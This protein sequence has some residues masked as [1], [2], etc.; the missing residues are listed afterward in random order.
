MP[1]NNSDQNQ[2]NRNSFT[3]NPN[4]SDKH[5]GYVSL[6]PQKDLH[7]N[8]NELQNTYALHPIRPEST[9][10]RAPHTRQHDQSNIQH[11]LQNPVQ[12]PTNPAQT[13]A[14]NYGTLHPQQSLS[15]QHTSINAPVNP[16]SNTLNSSSEKLINP[17]NFEKVLGQENVVRPV[18]Q[19]L[20]PEERRMQSL[21]ISQNLKGALPPVEIG[22]EYKRNIPVNTQIVLNRNEV[23]KLIIYVIPFIAILFQ[24]VKPIDDKDFKWHIKQSL[25]AQ[26]VWFFVM[27]VLNLL[28]IYILSTV[29]LT[30]WKLLGYITILITGALAYNGQRMHIPIAYDLGKNFIEEK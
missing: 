29:G 30:L 15:H 14:Q 27:I 16:A 7:L 5:I 24:L 10:Q 1:G 9:N 22:D 13:S 4:I 12:S 20:T 21:E 28:D 8:Q 17:H 2:A 26:G 3:Q 19:Q 23:L 6:D 25:V 18:N 11:Q